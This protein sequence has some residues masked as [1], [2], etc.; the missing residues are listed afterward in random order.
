MWAIERLQGTAKP[1]LDELD[2]KPPVGRTLKI[3]CG[4]SEVGTG[5]GSQK[6]PMKPQNETPDMPLIKELG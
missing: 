4:S 1:L 3:G 6:R 5:L 2:I